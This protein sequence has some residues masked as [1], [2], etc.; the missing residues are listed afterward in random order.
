[1]FPTLLDFKGW[2]VIPE[3]VIPTFFFMCMFGGLVATFY[4]YYRAPKVGLSQ[5]AILDVG[6]IGIGF[7]VIGGRLFH[8]FVEDWWFYEDNLFRILEIWRGGFVSYGAFIGGSIAILT[9]LKV[10]KLPMLKYADLLATSLPLVIFFVRVGCLGAGCCHG[11]PTDFFIHLV[12]DHH[13]S[14]QGQP[15]YSGVPLHATQVY[16]MTYALGLFA[17]T[18]WLYK[19]KK[20]DGQVVV[21]FFMVYAVVRALLEILRGDMERGVYFDGMISTAQIVG[22]FVFVICA[23]LYGVLKRYHQRKS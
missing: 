12:F 1:M 9:Y 14:P 11:T 10:R 6:M 22:F 13:Y 19:R 5:V 17:F 20:F 3:I 16:A 21:V 7:G 2:G 23:V 8:V 15:N 18:N 4:C